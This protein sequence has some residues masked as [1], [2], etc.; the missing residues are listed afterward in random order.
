MSKTDLAVKVDEVRLFMLFA[1]FGGKLER[2][3]AVGN[4]PL[5]VVT[6]LAHDFNWKDKINGKNDLTTDEGKEYEK[7]L[8]RVSS[9]VSATRMANVFGRIIDA[10]DSDPEYARAFCTS[11][12][13]ETGEKS[14]NTKNLVEL[15]KGM[16]IVDDLRY[17]ALGD[18]VAQAADTTGAK[19]QAQLVLNVYQTLASRFDRTKVVNTSAEVVTAVDGPKPVG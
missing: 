14:F 7:A 13:D 12:D 5:E 18:K 8:N 15:A 4:V 3:A 16:Q 6:A 19:S 11:I 10:L 1:L 2:V 9:Y 17:R